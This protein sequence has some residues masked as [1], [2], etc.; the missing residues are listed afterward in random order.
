MTDEE[1]GKVFASDEDKL[2][3]ALTEFE[4][5]SKEFMRC[6][7][8]YYRAVVEIA[9]KRL[10]DASDLVSRNRSIQALMSVGK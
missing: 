2:N 9:T 3:K 8:H 6:R 4:V 5:A 1:L 10:L 7:C